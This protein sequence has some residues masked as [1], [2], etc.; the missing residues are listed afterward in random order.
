[1]TKQEMRE[2]TFLVLSA[3]A[4]GPKHGYALIAETRSMSEGRVQLKAGTLYAA[5][6]RLRDEGLVENAGED[7]IDGR[8]RRYFK[9]T[10][11]GAVR[12]EA[13]AARLQA[14][15]RM[16]MSNLGFRARGATT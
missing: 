16:A 15:A 7:V 3:L 10:D 9:L 13:E 4:G 6:D 5:L 11:A 8:L 14:N 1:M 12:L 2:P